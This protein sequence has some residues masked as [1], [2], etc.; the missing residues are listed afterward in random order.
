MHISTC[1]A[2]V[3]ADYETYIHH[4]ATHTACFPTFW[5]AWPMPKSSPIRQHNP[6]NM[7]TCNTH[8]VTAISPLASIYA[9]SQQ[10][11]AQ[12]LAHSIWLHIIM[13]AQP[14]LAHKPPS[15]LTSNQQLSHQCYAPP[16]RVS[17]TCYCSS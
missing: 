3:S 12:C 7:S 11:L 2:H 8:Q 13:A 16:N 15:S 4:S 1:I 17:T 10:P 6:H 5:D 9:F 14:F